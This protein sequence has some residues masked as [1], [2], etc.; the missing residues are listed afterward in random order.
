MHNLYN[1]DG[2]PHVAEKWEATELESIFSIAI[3]AL[4]MGRIAHGLVLQVDEASFAPPQAKG[5]IWLVP[6]PGV[7]LDRGLLVGTGPILAGEVFTTVFNLTN[8]T[9]IIRKGESVSYL[10]W[11]AGSPW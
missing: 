8:A 11:V 4:C 9:Q 1:L 6:K 5:N 7:M 2:S 3:P 10:M